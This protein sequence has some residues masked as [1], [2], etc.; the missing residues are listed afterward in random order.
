[1]TSTESQAT[2]RPVNCNVALA[3]L[4]SFTLIAGCV[5]RD[6]YPD[7]W[8]ALNAVPK[9][10]CADISGRYRNE[11]IQTGNC[12][13]GD[14]AYKAGWN[15]DLRLNWALGEPVNAADEQWVEIRQPEPDQIVI[16]TATETRVLRRSAG[17]FACDDDG[18][19]VSQHASIF[20]EQGQ[21]TGA[22]ATLTAMELMVASGGVNSLTL[23]FRRAADGSL[24]ARL[25]ESSSGL[26][27]AIPFHMSSL[28]YLRWGVWTDEAT[29]I[30]TPAAE[31]PAEESPP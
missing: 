25:S 3:V 7:Y 20:S 18:I 17:D 13:A 2:C 27:L 23:H 28:H 1:M 9:S 30:E 5:T 29:G 24:V 26:V 4:A 15:C 21:S 12:Y 10:A 6:P 11:A 19:V 8:P 22:N 16:V 14:R 31:I